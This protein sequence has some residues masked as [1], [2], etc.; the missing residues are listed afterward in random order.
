MSETLRPCKCGNDRVRI[1]KHIGG[2]DKRQHQATCLACGRSGPRLDDP[3]AAIADWN[4]AT[5]HLDAVEVTQPEP[6]ADLVEQIAQAAWG[7]LNRS[8]YGDK[9]ELYTPWKSVGESTKDAYRNTARA[10]LAAAPQPPAQAVAVPVDI[11]SLATNAAAWAFLDAA[12]NELNLTYH[13]A[14]GVWFKQALCA[15]ITKYLSAIADWNQAADRHLDAVE[16]A[17]PEPTP[18]LVAALKVAIHNGLG[19]NGWAYSNYGQ[20]EMLHCDDMLDGAA[21]AV[22]ALLQPRIEAAEGHETQATVTAWQD[23]VFGPPHGPAAPLMRA[24]NEMVEACI[25]LGIERGQFLDRVNTEYDRQIAKGATVDP[26][27]LP[28]EVAGVVTILYRVAQAAGF[29]LQQAVNAEM[30]KNRGRTAFSG[31]D[32][33]VRPGRKH[34][35][36]ASPGSAS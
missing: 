14:C 3:G 36:A 23:T 34:D 17:Q 1:T 28:S 7:H 8:V 13:A 31:G 2:Q 18:D 15:A 29:D 9:S 4:Q 16:V 26:G 5:R 27:N 11:G 33:K 35:R 21:R 6:P 24:I 12:P 30:R 19:G 32:G 22:I 10:M 25:S 20:D